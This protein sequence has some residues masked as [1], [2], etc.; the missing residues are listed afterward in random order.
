MKT[1]T[2]LLAH[3]DFTPSHVE[4]IRV[5]VTDETGHH[6][7][8]LL[9]QDRTP[10]TLAGA[11]RHMA[12]VLDGKKSFSETLPVCPPPPLEPINIIRI[13]CTDWE[14]TRRTNDQGF[15]VDLKWTDSEGKVHTEF[16]APDCLVPRKFVTPDGEESDMIF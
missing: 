13:H 8:S 6:M 5:I 11:L 2:I 4:G 3:S 1:A 16:L 9:I 10:E 15:G 12:D 7:E 14:Y